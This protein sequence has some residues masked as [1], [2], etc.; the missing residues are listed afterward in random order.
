[1]GTV[2]VSARQPGLTSV[3]TSFVP[4]VCV[5]LSVMEDT[6][7]EANSLS[8]SPT[9]GKSAMVQGSQEDRTIVFG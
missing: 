4:L 8:Q 1:M 2:P 5:L 7:D 6:E 9:L 3:A